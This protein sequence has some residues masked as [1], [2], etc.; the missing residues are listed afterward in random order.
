MGVEKQ[1]HRALRLGDP[2]H[3]DE[4]IGRLEFGRGASGEYEGVVDLFGKLGV[5]GESQ[6]ELA[7][8]DLEL[9]LYPRILLLEVLP[10]LDHLPDVEW[11]A[12]YPR[13]AAVLG[14][15]E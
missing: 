13:S 15:P 5:V 3:L 8:A 12:E 4:G 1:P 7:S 11:G 6:P 2:E 9:L 14:A 10:R